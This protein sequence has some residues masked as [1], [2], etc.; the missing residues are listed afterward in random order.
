ML[1]AA[2]SRQCCV[3][4]FRERSESP[5]GSAPERAPF[6]DLLSRHSR[7]CGELFCGRKVPLLRAC[8]RSRVF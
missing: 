8:G 7:R 6:L 2:V 5:K 1:R 3:T 4:S